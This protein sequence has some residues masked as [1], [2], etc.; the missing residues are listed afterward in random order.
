[1]R[2]LAR[3]EICSNGL[4]AA[5]DIVCLCGDERLDAQQ[6]HRIGTDMERRRVASESGSVRLLYIRTKKMLAI[7]SDED[8]QC[9]TDKVSVTYL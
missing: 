3:L 5:L 1:M 7:V 8:D 4:T 9:R 2:H 6:F